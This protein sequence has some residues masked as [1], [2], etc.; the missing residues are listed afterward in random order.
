MRETKINRLVI[1]F[2][3]EL[4]FALFSKKA[5]MLLYDEIPEFPPKPFLKNEKE[6][7]CWNLME[8]N[9]KENLVLHIGLVKEQG[10]EYFRIASWDYDNPLYTKKASIEEL[11][12]Q[13]VCLLELR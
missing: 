11:Q 7:F 3:G 5:K 9:K 4:G 12:G 1:K 8:P 2:L 6:V 10:K 13:V